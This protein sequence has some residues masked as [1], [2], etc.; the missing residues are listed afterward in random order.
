LANYP[1]DN[2]LYVYNFYYRLDAYS[3]D[4]N[5]NG[6]FDIGSHMGHLL[7]SNCLNIDKKLD[8]QTLETFCTV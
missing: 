4:L 1:F 8:S 5:H 7:L 2:L 6:A 3:I